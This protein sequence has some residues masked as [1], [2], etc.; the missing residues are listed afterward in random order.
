[1]TTLPTKEI[2]IGLWKGHAYQLE[3]RWWV[4]PQSIAEAMGLNWVAARK[5]LVER[6]ADDIVLIRRDA[7]MGCQKP[8]IMPLDV[9]VQWLAGFAGN[10][11]M[12]PERREI[13][14][15]MAA[16]IACQFAA[17]AVAD[18]AAAAPA[19]VV[20]LANGGNDNA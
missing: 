12:A 20:P 8:V 10:N 1:M 17:L 14:K 3:D 5:K 4:K 13:A 2:R 16:S 7:G 9:A 19:D 6:Y 15:Q 11:H 18:G